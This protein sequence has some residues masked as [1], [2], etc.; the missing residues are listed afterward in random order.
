[1]PAGYPVEEALVPHG[2][3]VIVTAAATFEFT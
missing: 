3:S 2:Q 1:V